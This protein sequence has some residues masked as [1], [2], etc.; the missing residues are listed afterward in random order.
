MLT[1]HLQLLGGLHALGHG[2]HVEGARQRYDRGDQRRDVGRVGDALHEGL[3]DLERVDRQLGQEAQRGIAG[4][5]IVDRDA[6]ARASRSCASLRMDNSK[7]CISMLS[8]I[9][10]SK[11]AAAEPKGSMPASTRSTKSRRRNCSGET[12]TATRMSRE[13]ASCQ[14]RMSRT[15]C[16]RDP[17]ANIDDGAGALEQRDEQRRRHDAHPQRPASAAAL[18]DPRSCRS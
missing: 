11:P 4:A 1:Q 17:L 16:S 14:L 18:R 3:V 9:S 12:L 7:S 15:A 13:P 5:E 6:D 8:V 2:L 10:I